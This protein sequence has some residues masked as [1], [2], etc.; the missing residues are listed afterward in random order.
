MLNIKITP[1]SVEVTRFIPITSGISLEPE[2][3]DTY[4]DSWLKGEF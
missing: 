3:K 2:N 4:F 1:G